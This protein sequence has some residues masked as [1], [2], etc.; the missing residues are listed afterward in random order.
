MDWKPRASSCVTEK[1]RVEIYIWARFI[2]TIV[3]IASYL[4]TMTWHE[5]WF[6][7]CH[8]MFDFQLY[9]SFIRVYKDDWEDHIAS[10][11]TYLNNRLLLIFLAH[12]SILHF[13]KT[14][15]CTCVAM[16]IVFRLSYSI[17]PTCMYKFLWYDYQ[18]TGLHY[19][20]PSL[21]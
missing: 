10:A 6:L 8:T 1:H 3:S 4:T 18:H 12:C 19:Q 16:L 7:L 15:S 2:N 5:H 11:Y 20:T 17:Q 14:Y 13:P 9:L 21:G